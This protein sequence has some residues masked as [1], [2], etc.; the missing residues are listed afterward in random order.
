MGVCMLVS[1]VMF[2]CRSFVAL[3]YIENIHKTEN[4]AEN[5]VTHET[6]KSHRVE[7]ITNLYAHT[8]NDRHRNE[9]TEN[10]PDKPVEKSISNTFAV[11]PP[12]LGEDEREEPAR[13]R[14][15]NKMHDPTDSSCLTSYHARDHWHHAHHRHQHAEDNSSCNSPNYS[16]DYF[17]IHKVCI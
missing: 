11:I 12:P 5:R 3:C 16:T 4:H 15:N 10:P 6:H 17:L 9:G 2:V 8:E 1:M 13:D 14:T 7:S